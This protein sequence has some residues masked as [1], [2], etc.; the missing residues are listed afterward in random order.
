M[1]S[2]F[3][4]TNKG[5][6]IP[7]LYLTKPHIF[8]DERGYFYE[9]WNKKSFNTMIGNNV[10]FVQDNQSS[11]KKGVLRGLHYQLNPTPQGKLI[12]CLKG[13]IF[14][15]A[16]DLRRNSKTFSEWVGVYLNDK[17]KYQFWIPEGFAHGFLTISESANVLYKTTNFWDKNLERCI[18][19]DDENLSIN[20]PLD[21]LNLSSPS[22]S[23]KDN[24]ACSFKSALINLEVF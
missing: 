4:K 21:K 24:K 5:N 12:S 15:V 14:D 7:D 9:Y 20:W 17:N 6:Y 11:S 8:Q 23:I 10:D 3:L 18:K 22:L 16:I 2:K 13:E 19:W 1:L